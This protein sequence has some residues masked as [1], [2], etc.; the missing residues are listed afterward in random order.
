MYHARHHPCHFTSLTGSGVFPPDH[1]RP[2][3]VHHQRVRGEE[4]GHGQQ[5]Q[6]IDL[7]PLVGVCKAAM[8]DVQC[9]V[10]YISSVQLAAV[11]YSRTVWYYSRHDSHGD[12]GQG[13]GHVH[14]RQEGALVGEVD[15]RFDL[16]WD[17]QRREG[18]HFCIA[19]H[20]Q[21]C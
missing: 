11:T 3:D 16:D 8:R 12:G 20:R 1:S 2:A 6:S 18:R 21:Q 13:N 5:H 9:T 14:P 10:T 4:D 19:F 7:G 15:L 17:L